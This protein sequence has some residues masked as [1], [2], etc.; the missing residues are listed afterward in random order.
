MPRK[1]KDINISLTK[2]AS[3]ISSTKFYTQSTHEE[4]PK[5]KDN[6]FTK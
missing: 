3:G 2:P 6:P 5:V 4:M 1:A